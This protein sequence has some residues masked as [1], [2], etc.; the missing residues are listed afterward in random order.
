MGSLFQD[1]RYGLR[2]L[3]KSPGFTVVAVI[4]LALGIGANTTIFTLL[5]A[6]FLHRLP[7]EDIRSLVSV[8]T[9]DAKNSGRFLDFM[10]MSVPNFRDFRDQGD[11]FSALVASTGVP[12]GVT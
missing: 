9:A 1:L 7:V 5:N 6:V 8:F 10:P 12:V 3:G 2:L 11:A 4:S